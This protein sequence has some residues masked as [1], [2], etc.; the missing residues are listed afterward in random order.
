VGL[1]KRL[2]C[3]PLPTVRR[4]LKATSAAVKCDSY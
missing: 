3:R 4:W 2:P 1:E